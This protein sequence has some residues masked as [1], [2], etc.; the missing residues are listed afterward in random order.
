M[1]GTG[2]E[3]FNIALV[4]LDSEL[5]DRNARIVHILHDEIIVEAREDMAGDLAVTVKNCI[6]RAFNEIFPEVPFVV[7]PDIRDS[8]EFF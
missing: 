3:G 8:R 2:A 1:Q 5:S 4:E 6:E 7:K